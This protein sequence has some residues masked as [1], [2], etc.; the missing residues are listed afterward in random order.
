MSRKGEIRRPYIQCSLPGPKRFWLR[1]YQRGDCWEFRGQEQAY[2]SF[3][4]EHGMTVLAHRYAFSLV[5]DLRWDTILDHTCN[6]PW[7]VRPSHLVAGDT[8]ENTLRGIGP[9]ASNARKTHCRFGHQLVPKPRTPGV[10][11]C[12]LCAITGARQ[13]RAERTPYHW[14]AGIMCR[15]GHA[16]TDENTTIRSNG[17]LRCKTCCK[18]TNRARYWQDQQQRPGQLPERLKSILWKMAAPYED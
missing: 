3:R 12:R 11:Y 4:V 7:C 16:F 13:R 6:H 5:K 9:T 14:P 8:R 18:E 10:R 15:K 2:R 1:V 17:Q